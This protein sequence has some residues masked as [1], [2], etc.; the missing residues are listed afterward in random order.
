MSA[1]AGKQ[2][3]KAADKYSTYLTITEDFAQKIIADYLDQ[4]ISGYPHG[5]RKLDFLDV[6]SGPGIATFKLIDRFGDK[7]QYVAT[8]IAAAMLETLQSKAQ[9]LNIPVTTKVQDGQVRPRYLLY[10]Y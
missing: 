7:A 6:A 4:A 8:D 3:D 1:D 10:Q 5:S 2:W 9:K